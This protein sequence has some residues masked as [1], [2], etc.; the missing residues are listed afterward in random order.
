MP[1]QVIFSVLSILYGIAVVQALLMAVFF[2]FQKKGITSSRFIL[3]LLMLVFAIFLTGTFLLLF[4]G[5]WRYIYYA[6]LIN[7]SIFLAPPL[8]YFYFLSLIDQSFR[9]TRQLLV[10]A[11]PFAAIFLIMLYVVVFRVDRYFVFRPFG[12]ILIAALFAQNIYYLRKIYVEKKGAFTNGLSSKAKWF[13]YLFGGIFFIFAFKL[14]TFVIWNVLDYVDICI[15]FTGMFFILSF[16][17]INML[18]L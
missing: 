10:H 13:G 8:L 16:I 15:F 17:L 14:L 3:A 7:L 5:R 6:H 9:F 2:V 18:V 12:L 4:F 11:V 1:I